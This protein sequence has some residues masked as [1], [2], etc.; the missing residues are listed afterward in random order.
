MSAVTIDLGSVMGCAANATS[1][2]CW[3]TYSWLDDD[4]GT[5]VAED[6]RPSPTVLLPERTVFWPGDIQSNTILVMDT[7][8]RYWGFDHVFGPLIFP[9]H[10]HR[11]QQ[12]P[13]V[14]P[15]NLRAIRATNSR[16]CFL[17]PERALRCF[18]ARDF[19][20]VTF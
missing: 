19:F 16:A 18:Q 1:T 8:A 5:M 4:P 14:D 12:I 20:E 3:G 15:T 9:N 7:E 11:N 2:Y 6:E 13:D 10:I 17:Y